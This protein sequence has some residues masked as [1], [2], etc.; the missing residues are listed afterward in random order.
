MLRRHVN[1]ATAIGSGPK[2]IRIQV[3]YKFQHA[4]PFWSPAESFSIYIG[5][6]K[7]TSLI[8]QIEVKAAKPFCKRTKFD[9]MISLYMAHGTGIPW[10]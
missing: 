4:L 3:I 1:F 5:G 8:Q 2:E 9:T 7:G 6:H 10:L